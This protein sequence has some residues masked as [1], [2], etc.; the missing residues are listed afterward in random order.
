MNVLH[1]AQNSTFKNHPTDIVCGENHLYGIVLVHIIHK[2]ALNTTKHLQVAGY[3][4][5]KNCQNS[6]F[7]LTASLTTVASLEP[8]RSSAQS[9]FYTTITNSPVGCAFWVPTSVC[10]VHIVFP[11]IFNQVG[12]L[13]QASKP[14]RG[15]NFLYQYFS[16][17]TTKL[18]QKAL[19]L[20]KEQGAY[21]FKCCT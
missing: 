16:V 17:D 21:N 8:K 18:F 7:C 9:P 2:T 12:C 5:L 14:Y 10:P 3:K 13:L 11:F 4:I 15:I 19:M 20:L 6:N 1:A